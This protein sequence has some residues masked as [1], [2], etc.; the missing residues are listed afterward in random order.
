MSKRIKN[1]KHRPGVNSIVC[2]ECDGP[3]DEHRYHLGYEQCVKCSDVEKY[4]G[5]MVYP[6]KTGGEI[7]VLSAESYNE[8]KKYFIPHGTH[9]CV[10]NFSK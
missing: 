2:S 5:H 1:S 9:S 3:L 6:H 8:N 10:K 4:S 7:E